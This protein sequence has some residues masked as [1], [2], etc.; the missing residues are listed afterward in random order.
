MVGTDIGNVHKQRQGTGFATILPTGDEIGYYYKL[1][2]EQKN[3]AKAKVA[4]KNEALSKLKQPNDYWYRHDSELKTNVEEIQ[5]AGTALLEKGINPFTDGS[6]EALEFR[7]KYDRSMQ[8]AA[9]SKQ[10]KSQY[11]KYSTDLSNGNPDD[12]DDAAIAQID[13]FY[14]KPLSEI[15]D[16]NMVPPHLM[17]KRPYQD[18]FNFMG[19]NMTEWSRGWNGNIPNDDKVFDFV[20]ALVQDPANRENMIRTYGAKLAQ[21]PPQEKEWVMARAKKEMVEPHVIMA[22][23]DANRWKEMKKPFSPLEL[24][25]KGADAVESGLNYVVNS[26]PNYA[27]KS[28]NKKDMEKSLDTVTAALFNERPEWFDYY[29]QRVQRDPSEN[30]GEY[31]TRVM[32]ALKED[33]RPLVAL[34]TESKLTDR[35]KDEKD[36]L[37]KRN[38]WIRDLRST[39]PI[40]K[41]AAAQ[42]VTNMSIFGNLNVENASIAHDM[43]GAKLSMK[44][45]TDLALAETKSQVASAIPGI[46]ESAI[47]VVDRQGQKY[48]EVS[49][50]EDE[51]ANQFL[52]AIYDSNYK[53]R[54]SNY[55]TTISE[56][57]PKT[58]TIAVPLRTDN[59]PQR[60]PVSDDLFK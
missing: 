19:K 32:A 23:D 33:I 25:K 46:S 26:N 34:N 49:L 11:E 16:K 10:I 37:S 47:S 59:L 12:Y 29:E 51:I 28:F 50:G 38:D 9:A 41:S 20:D 44:A 45:M 36:F 17:K 48:V 40:K 54:K 35:G 43:F 42:W 56:K 15:V 24:L 14:G 30:D 52:A 8:L 21:M 5:N 55:D 31:A 58:G 1:S 39:D 3:K 2:D 60:R 7:K 53:Q 27:S 4:A 18:A 6:Q 13:D 22:V 57:T